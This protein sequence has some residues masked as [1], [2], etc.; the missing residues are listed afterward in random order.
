MP[1]PAIWCS[2]FSVGE[3]AC[4]AAG[5]KTPVRKLAQDWGQLDGAGQCFLPITGSKI[6]RCIAAQDPPWNTS[7]PS[8]SS[9]CSFY[10]K[11]DAAL[12]STLARS[13]RGNVP[14]VA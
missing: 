2:D 3:F 11:P 1:C 7:G 9:M 4:D 10:R 8:S 13:K 12:A 5:G 14:F 6:L